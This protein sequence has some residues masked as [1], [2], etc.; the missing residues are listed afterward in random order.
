MTSRLASCSCGNIRVTVTGEPLRVSVCHCL[1]CQR[2]TGSPFGAQ[3][4]FPN[5]AVTVEGES[6]E[7]VRVADSGTRLFFRFCPTCGATVYY[8]VEDQPDRTALPLG[9]FADP[10]FPAPAFSVYESR[11]HP[12]VAILG[13]VDHTS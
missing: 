4:R 3:V 11:M 12:W 1:A 10:A 5:E 8:T 13:D 2:R 7:Y 9:A 6:K